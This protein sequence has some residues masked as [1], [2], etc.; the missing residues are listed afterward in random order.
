MRL[1]GSSQPV[2]SYTTYINISCVHFDVVGQTVIP[3]AII[4]FCYSQGGGQ[5]QHHGMGGL[6]GIKG[7]GMG[8]PGGVQ[9]CC[10]SYC[11]LLLSCSATEVA[12]ARSQNTYLN[13]TK[14]FVMQDGAFVGGVFAGFGGQQA[15][16]M[17]NNYP[18]QWGAAAALGGD[19][20]G[21]G[22]HPARLGDPAG[23]DSASSTEQ[24]ESSKAAKQSSTDRQVSVNQ[25]GVMPRCS[26]FR[27]YATQSAVLRSNAC[28]KK[29]Q[30]YVWAGAHLCVCADIGLISS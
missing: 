3:K 10:S 9:V 13:N 8:N 22:G 6:G 2:R 28:P 21:L 1:S 23:H 7:G 5:H 29:G 18:G 20:A 11:G 30:A 19:F 16:Q 14:N 15:Q 27:L 25:Y 12:V 24:A 17:F 4:G 26:C